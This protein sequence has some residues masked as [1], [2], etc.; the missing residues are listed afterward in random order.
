MLVLWKEIH[1]IGIMNKL[2]QY[3]QEKLKITSNTKINSK[4]KPRDRGELNLMILKKVMENNSD[5]TDIDVSEMEDLSDLFHSESYK[6]IDITGWNLKKCKT[7]QG[8]F[9]EC[10]YLQKIIGIDDLDISNVE[11]LSF[12]FNDCKNLKDVGDLGKWDVEGKNLAYAFQD[13]VKLKD[14]G[15]LTKWKLKNPHWSTFSNCSIPLNKRPP[16][17]I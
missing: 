5:F 14:A 7:M 1:H 9:N 13:C 8:M 12:I 16:K 3:I 15:D 4:Q 10:Q 2:Q 6:E 17:K 11:D